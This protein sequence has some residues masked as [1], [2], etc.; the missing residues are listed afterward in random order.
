MKVGTATATFWLQ[1]ILNAV[2]ITPERLSTEE[3]VAERKKNM[4]VCLCVHVRKK[5]LPP[6]H[7]RTAMNYVYVSLTQTPIVV[8]QVI[9]L[10]SESRAAL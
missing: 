4:A 2:F 1:E 3:Q 10:V 5:A 7:C 6:I 8:F 9:Q